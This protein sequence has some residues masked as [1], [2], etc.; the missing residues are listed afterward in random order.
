MIVSVRGNK[1]VNKKKYTEKYVIYKN[2]QT[3]NVFF[4]QIFIHRDFDRILISLSATNLF[5]LSI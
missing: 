2:I 1:N 4:H 5:T 3:T